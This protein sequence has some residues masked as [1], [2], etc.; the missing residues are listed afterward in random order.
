MFL[1][2]V[3]EICISTTLPLESATELIYSSYMVVFAIAYNFFFI[4]A[5]YC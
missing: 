4:L 5:S 3:F 2:D 1:I